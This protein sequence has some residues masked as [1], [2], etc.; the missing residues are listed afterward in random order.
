MADLAIV[1]AGA[2]GTHTLL[3][4]LERLSCAAPDGPAPTRIV[5][6]DR[7]PQFFAGVAWGNRSGPSSLTLSTV[8]RFL[9]DQERARFIAWLDSR[10][11]RA[12]D[13]AVDPEWIDRHRADVTAGRWDHLFVP[14]RWYGE[15]LA[16]RARTAIADARAAGVA[17]VEL[18]TADVTAVDRSEDRHLVTAVEGGG[19][20]VTVDAAAVVLALGSPPTRRLPGTDASSDGPIHDIYDPG[21]PDTLARLHRDLAALP[22]GD[23]RVLVVGGNASALEFLLASRGVI[24]ELGAPVTVLSPSGRPRHWRGKRDD[25]EADLPAITALRARAVD[26]DRVTAAELHDA[27]AADL[28]DAVAA[29]TDVAAVAEIAD[30][31]P[32][33]LATLADEDRAA[34]A[35]GYGLSLTRMLRHDCGDGVDLLASAVEAGTVDFH[36]GRYLRCRRD[37]AHF[38]VTIADDE[39]TEHVL[40]GAFGA[41][42][43]AIGFEG[44]SATT[45]PLLRRMLRAGLVEASSSDAGLRVDSRFQAAPR[46][47]VVGPLL[48]GNAHPNMLIWHAESVRRIMAIAREAAPHI[49]RELVGHLPCASLTSGRHE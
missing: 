42:V 2:S 21:L 19:G 27:V 45:A 17:E 1:G 33:L 28:R 44:V 12:R 36:A 25:E 35:A 34:L 3:A 9:P 48:A 14:R 23:R 30:S 22:A 18:R 29:G 41:I 5:V 32:L 13:T 46:L 6:I 7:D 20:V 26:G 39:G 8:Q 37:G 43:G 15:Y 24:G 47:F 11:A 16:H 10:S 49:A 4:L 31:V 40:D 38:R